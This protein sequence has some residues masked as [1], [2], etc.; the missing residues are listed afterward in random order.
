MNALKLLVLSKPTPAPHFNQIILTAPDIDSGVFVR[1]AKVIRGSAERITL[2]A[3]SHDI[4]LAASKKKN[5]SYPRAGDCSDSVAVVS[6]VDTIDASAVDTNL[7]GHFY[8]AENRSVLSDIFT[9]LRDGGPPP[10]FG[11]RPVEVTPPYWRFAP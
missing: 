10:R 4:A 7:I 9:L 8:Y 11:I 5:A 3:S 2:Y 6:G 1:I